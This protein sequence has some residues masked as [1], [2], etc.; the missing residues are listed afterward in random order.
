MIGNYFSQVPRFS[1][2]PITKIPKYVY[3]NCNQVTCHTYSDESFLQ[4]KKSAESCTKKELAKDFMYS[5]EAERTSR[6]EELDWIYGLSALEQELLP[7]GSHLVQALTVQ[8]VIRYNGMFSRM[9]NLNPGQFRT[10]AIRWPK[11]D[12][13]DLNEST[14]MYALE[15]ILIKQFGQ[16]ATN[17]KLRGISDPKLRKTTLLF[18]R[19]A[20]EDIIRKNLEIAARGEL[21]FL[22]EQAKVNYEANRHTI[23][24]DVVKTWIEK[25]GRTDDKLNITQWLGERVHY[26]P[27][28]LEIPRQLDASLEAIKDPRMHPIQKAAKIWFDVVDLHISHEANKRTGKALA[29]AI[30]LSFGYLPP[31]IGPAN[32]KEYVK[33]LIDGLEDPQGLEKFTQFVLKMM[34]KTYQEYAGKKSGIEVAF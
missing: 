8:R 25:Q 16:E 9:D 33:T 27:L 26:F 30:L 14:V 12:I 20:I 28:P 7:A 24:P 2:S 17:Q 18:P 15:M 10:H 34:V 5:S 29:S 11:Y 6:G 22:D 21:V 4:H 23:T 19:T 32:A 1:D 3:E 13:S 31:K